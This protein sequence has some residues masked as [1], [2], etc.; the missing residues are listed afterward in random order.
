M[1]RLLSRAWRIRKLR[2]LGLYKVMF[3]LEQHFT[4][5]VAVF[6]KKVEFKGAGDC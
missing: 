6:I 5:E 4:D 1:V 3:R 2:C